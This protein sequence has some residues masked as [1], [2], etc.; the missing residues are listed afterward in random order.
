MPHNQFGFLIKNPNFN[1]N[2]WTISK[3][4]IESIDFVFKK[5]STKIRND[6]EQSLDYFNVALVM[7][8]K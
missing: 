6:V 7:C 3:R 4:L 8:A 5:K 2:F 1:L